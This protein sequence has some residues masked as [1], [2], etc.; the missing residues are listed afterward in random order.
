[1]Q[2][3]CMANGVLRM[4]V[5]PELSKPIMMILIY[6]L[7]HSFENIF[8]KKFPITEALL[9]NLYTNQLN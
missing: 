9:I 8:P 1:M 5:L 2:L 3:V 6:F 4:V 7:L